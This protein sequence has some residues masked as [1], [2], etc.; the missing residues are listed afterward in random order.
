[1]CTRFLDGMPG[2][3]GRLVSLIDLWMK[4]PRVDTYQDVQANPPGVV[5][6]ERHVRVKNLY[7]HPPRHYTYASA[8]PSAPGVVQLLD[9]V[10]MLLNHNER[11]YRWVMGALGHRVQRPHVKDEHMT[12]LVGDY[13]IGKSKFGQLLTALVGLEKVF[14]S[15]D[16][17]HMLGKF[18]E[19]L[20][21]RFFV[22]FEEGSTARTDPGKYKNMIRSKYLVVEEKYK[23]LRKIYNG[24][25]NFVFS[26]G[27]C[28][29]PEIDRCLVYFVCNPERQKDYAYFAGIDALI[30]DEAVMNGL[31]KYLM[32]LDW[33][34]AGYDPV[35]QHV[36]ADQHILEQRSRSWD[37]IFQECI[38]RALV[39]KHNDPAYRVT[40]EGKEHWRITADQI[41]A[42]YQRWYRAAHTDGPLLDSRRVSTALSVLW[43]R[44]GIRGGGPQ[45]RACTVYY[46]DVSAMA[47]LMAAEYG[48]YAVETERCYERSATT[49]TPGW[50]DAPKRWVLHIDPDIPECPCS[51]SAGYRGIVFLDGRTPKAPVTLSADGAV[52][53]TLPTFTF[54]EVFA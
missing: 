7:M 18:N 16:G 30:A 28:P 14:E 15:A 6:D 52:V 32:E 2:P 53:N 49:Y 36:S 9:F 24:A 33:R 13:G 43:K 17:N 11:D 40:V 23:P 45:A 20:E 51:I 48:M 10:R 42:L 34:A 1:M 46:L 22:I 4:D 44:K 50:V 25:M 39:H 8:D 29:V 19:V 27:T 47:R 26:N 12:V 41:Y 31:Y 5:L 3:N 35:R 54:Q 21:G 37:G 38:F